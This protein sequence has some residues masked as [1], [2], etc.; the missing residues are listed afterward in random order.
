M[1]LDFDKSLNYERHQR[2][3]SIVV[4]TLV[5]RGLYNQNAKF[6]GVAPTAC[7]LIIKN[8]VLYHYM[9]KYDGKRRMENWLQNN[10]IKSFKDQ[11][12]IYSEKLE[13]FN[14][15]YN[16]QP[17]DLFLALKLSHDF[18]VD[19]TEIILLGYE[20]PLYMKDIAPKE[21]IDFAFA[22][23]HKY[24]DV[25]KRNVDI[26]LK[27][28]N[29]LEE[30]YKIE[31]NT[32][33]YLTIDELEKFLKT[34]ELP[35]IEDRRKY[36]LIKYDGDYS[37]FYDQKTWNILNPK[38]AKEFV[39]GRTAFK[40]KV[41]GIVKV[42][43]KIKEADDLKEGEI[44]ITSMTDPRYVP[45]MKRAGAIV[46]DEGGITCHAAIVSRELKIPCVIGTKVATEIFKNGDM[47]EVDANS[48][49]VRKI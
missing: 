27:I 22:I 13:K 3:Y 19:F 25:H 33:S 5:F 24:E 12:K 46:T 32:L 35:D 28:L 37:F 45:A 26:T 44:L 18:F 14:K 10:N 20:L 39:R 6:F 16:Q 42:I 17:D 29:K 23:R 4:T 9:S 48:G 30:K 47:V 38:I 21:I 2:D 49:I 43:N 8:D 15:F 11:E 7:Y 31:K 34:A 1:N 36:V 40:G 41:Q